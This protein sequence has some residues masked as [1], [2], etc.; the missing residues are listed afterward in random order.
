MGARGKTLGKVMTS[1]AVKGSDVKKAPVGKALLFVPEGVSPKKQELN[2]QIVAV[3][4]K[5]FAAM[6]MRRS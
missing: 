5:N 6:V 3:D 4:R 2:I 1:K